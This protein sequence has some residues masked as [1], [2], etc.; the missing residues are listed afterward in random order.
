MDAPEVALFLVG[1]L[2][3]QKPGV[4]EHGHVCK[5]PEKDDQQ[6][7]SFDLD[8]VEIRDDD[9]GNSDVK[10]KAADGL[11]STFLQDFSAAQK[12]SEPNEKDEGRNLGKAFAH[13]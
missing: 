1:F 7:N 10:N 12:P 13:N 6:H 9:A 8:A 4:T 11:E 2:S 3:R 5:K